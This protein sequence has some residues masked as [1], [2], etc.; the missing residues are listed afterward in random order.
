MH[1]SDVPPMCAVLN[2]S[3]MSVCAFRPK[4]RIIQTLALIHKLLL[5]EKIA[6][7]YLHSMGLCVTD[8]LCW[9]GTC[10]MGS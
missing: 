10:E 7:C 4:E 2:L 6:W 8:F 1:T 5:A 3:M 9:Q